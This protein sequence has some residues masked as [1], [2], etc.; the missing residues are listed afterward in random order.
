MFLL[1]PRKK[2]SFRQCIRSLTSAFFDYFLFK[3]YLVLAKPQKI[4]ARY[5]SCSSGK[6]PSFVINIF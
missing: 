5:T 3:V 6:Q 2:E 4:I 1:H